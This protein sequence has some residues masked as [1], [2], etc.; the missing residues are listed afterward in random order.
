[1]YQLIRL[2]V[3]LF[4]S[5]FRV[6]V[7]VTYLFCLTDNDCC[8]QNSPVVNKSVTVDIRTYIFSLYA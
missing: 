2:F 6:Y 7:F 1:L 5:L 4:S 8:L 3:L